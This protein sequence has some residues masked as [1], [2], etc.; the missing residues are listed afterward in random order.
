M[1]KKDR[2]EGT[3]YL[4]D[5]IE[6]LSDEELAKMA[7]VKQSFF[8]QIIKR[9]ERKLISYIKKISNVSH[10]DAEDILQDVFIKVYK[11]LND[12]DDSLKFSSWIY[13]ICRNEVIS[14]W[15]KRRARPQNSP[16]EL[17]ENFIKGITSDL[18]IEREIDRKYLKRNIYKILD[19]LDIRHKDILIL[20]FFEECDYKEISD[21]MKMPMGTVASLMNRA[22]KEFRK[23]IKKII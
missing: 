5:S 9:Y 4:S 2:S 10:E 6:G 19:K 14:N 1:T 20:K 7:L 12:F 11:N 15:R 16:E 23:K 3:N 21:I 22:K 8:G 17:D 18:D 13:R